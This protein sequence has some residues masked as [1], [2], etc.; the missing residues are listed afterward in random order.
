VRSIVWAPAEA[1][2]E[3]Q[4]QRNAADRNGVTWIP[5]SPDRLP[6]ADVISRK[7]VQAYHPLREI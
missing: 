2:V 6:H 1:V 5:F 4:S 3:H 7:R